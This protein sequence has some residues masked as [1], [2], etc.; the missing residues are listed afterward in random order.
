MDEANF[1]SLPQK[2]SQLT[3]KPENT[4]SKR[5]KTLKIYQALTQAHVKENNR[6]S[7]CIITLD[8]FKF[9]AEHGNYE[10]NQAEYLKALKS[11]L[12]NTTSAKEKAWIAY[13]LAKFYIENANKAK[14]PDY[15]EKALEQTEYVLSLDANTIPEREVLKLKKKIYSSTFSVE[16]QES[17]LPNRPILTQVTTKNIDTLYVSV[18]KAPVNFYTYKKRKCSC[19]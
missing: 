18:Y 13:H 2:F 17:P 6:L 12:A 14:H 3:I 8:R 10:D 1:F 4:S 16:T 19:Y 11:F 5:Y 7:V 15:P 9:L